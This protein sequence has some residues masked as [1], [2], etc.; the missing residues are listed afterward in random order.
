MKI[1]KWNIEFSNTAGFALIFSVA[2]GAVI[3]SVA[4][5]SPLWL[6]AF[7]GGI[8]WMSWADN[9]LKITKER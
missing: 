5:L 8:L 9:E 3:V 7:A 4:Q 2:V 1:G 6:L